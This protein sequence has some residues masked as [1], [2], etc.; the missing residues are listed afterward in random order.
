[1]LSDNVMIDRRATI[2]SSVIMPATYVGQQVDVHDAIVDGDTLIQ[3]DTGVVTHV[4]DS[5]LLTS[6]DAH[7]MSSFLRGL[8]NRSR[9]IGGLVTARPLNWFR[10]AKGLTAQAIARTGLARRASDQP[11]RPSKIKFREDRYA[12]DMERNHTG[13]RRRHA[14]VP[15]NPRGL[16]AAHP[17]L[18]Q[19]HDLLSAGRAND[20]RDT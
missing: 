3:I 7:S 1:V 16:Q 8:W 5:F 20:G 10:A 19:T 12:N 17:D 2:R 13:G 18:R 15:G 9:A 6:V 14:T 11:A 4:K